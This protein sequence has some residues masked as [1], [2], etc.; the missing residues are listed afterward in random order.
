MAK[1]KVEIDKGKDGKVRMNGVIVFDPSRSVQP[2]LTY[3]MLDRI[4]KGRWKFCDDETQAILLG[5]IVE[6]RGDERE[7]KA[8]QSMLDERFG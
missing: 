8:F 4:A 3:E 5:V 6:L 2:E 1:G 7:N